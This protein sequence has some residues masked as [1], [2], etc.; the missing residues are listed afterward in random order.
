MFVVL[1]KFA[2]LPQYIFFFLVDKNASSHMFDRVIN[3]TVNVKKRLNA[4]FEKQKYFF[5]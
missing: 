3:P 5:Q 1:N 4:F 2:L